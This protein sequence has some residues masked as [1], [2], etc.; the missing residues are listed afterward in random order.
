MSFSVDIIED[1]H[2]DTMAS[3]GKPVRTYKRKYLLSSDSGS[4]VGCHAAREGF[5]SQTG[6]EKWYSSHPENTGA[7]CMNVVTTRHSTAPPH[8]KWDVDVDW[9]TDA[10]KMDEQDP[11]L[12][13]WM[14]KVNT[15]EQQRHVFRDRDDNLIVDSAGSPFDGGV[16]VNVRLPTITWTHNVAWS[17]Y[18]L[19][20]PIL[21]S[22][23]L[24]SDYFL[25][26][27]PG[28]LL[29]DVTADEAWEGNDFHYVKETITVTF[30][31]LSWQPK[32]ANAGLFEIVDGK[33]ERCTDDTGVP[34]TEPQPLYENGSMV[35]VENRPD[36]CTFITVQYYYTTAFSDLNLPLT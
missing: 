7:V 32:P 28:T 20:R 8:Q 18:D 27:D 2:A 14:R 3:D 33:R 26:C 34:A 19:T 30:D 9:T 12:R 4:F 21:L 5:T 29:L 11:A 24:N 36:D 10:P 16:P 1:S 31:P 35:P 25:G 17:D 15:S 22:G 13:R 6:I 23:R